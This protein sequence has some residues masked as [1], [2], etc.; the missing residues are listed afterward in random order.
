MK[1][2][3]FDEIFKTKATEFCQVLKGVAHQRGRIVHSVDIQKHK[4]FIYMFDI[5]TSIARMRMLP[6]SSIYTVMYNPKSDKYTW[7]EGYPR[8]SHEKVIN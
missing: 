2:L 4:A 8:N 3:E 7:H 1:D 5:R 6:V